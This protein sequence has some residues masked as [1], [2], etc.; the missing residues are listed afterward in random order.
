VPRKRGRSKWTKRQLT[1]VEKFMAARRTLAEVYKM[2]E[3]R[4]LIGRLT[5]SDV[6]ALLNRAYVL[7]GTKRCSI[8]R[9]RVQCW[10]RKP[11]Q[12]VIQ[13]WHLGPYDGSNRHMVA[14]SEKYE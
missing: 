13:E 8:S 3:R 9:R 11:P 7:K 2:L 10:I 1:A 4:I 12:A 5:S 6:R 14:S